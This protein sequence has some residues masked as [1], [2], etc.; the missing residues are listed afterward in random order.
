MKVTGKF[1]GK[2]LNWIPLILWGNVL[3]SFWGNLYVDH[4]S[5]GSLFRGWGCRL[6]VLLSC[7]VLFGYM[8]PKNIMESR[9][10]K[11]K[12]LQMFIWLRVWSIPS[13]SLQSYMNRKRA[14]LKNVNVY[15]ILACARLTVSVDDR[16]KGERGEIA[17]EQK[18]AGREKG[19]AWKHLFKYLNHPVSFPIPEK[20]F[21]VSNVKTS[22][23][24][25]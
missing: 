15:L 16:R 12:I 2:I 10:S 7:K 17:S 23:G 1:W 24:A 8:L 21:L 4:I 3:K 14:K 5:S 19:R 6:F 13:V 25:V 9:H 20:P 22:K 18:M 11:V